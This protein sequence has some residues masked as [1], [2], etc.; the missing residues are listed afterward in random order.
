[1]S[2]HVHPRRRVRIAAAGLC[3]ALGIGLLAFGGGS[4]NAG[5]ASAQ[6]VPSPYAGRVGLNTHEIWGAESG[7]Y[8]EFNGQV[9]CAECG[10]QLP[11]EEASFESNYAFCSSRCFGRFV[12]V[13]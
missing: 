6:T 4:G 12:G 10:K 7:T 13:Y 3:V 9:T 5:A 2:S 8:T 1:M 11:E